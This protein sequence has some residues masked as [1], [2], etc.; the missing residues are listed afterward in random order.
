[1]SSLNSAKRKNPGKNLTSIPRPNVITSLSRTDILLGRGAFCINHIGNVRFRETCSS[2]REE[3]NSTNR[4]RN[5][6]SIAQEIVSAIGADG[7]QFLREATRLELKQAGL[8]KRTK[9]WVVAESD[10]VL[11]KVKQTLRDKDYTQKVPLANASLPSVVPDGNGPTTI[12]APDFSN[13]DPQLVAMYLF[14]TLTDVQ[15]TPLRN[16][17]SGQSKIT[18]HL[19]STTDPLHP[20]LEPNHILENVGPHPPKTMPSMERSLHLQDVNATAGLSLTRDI[21][22]GSHTE[23]LPF[24]QETISYQGTT[25][26]TT[27]MVPATFQA[28]ETHPSNFWMSEAMSANGLHQRSMESLQLGHQAVL[29]NYIQT[30]Q[31]PVASSYERLIQ[32]LG[33]Q[34][35]T[36]RLPE[37]FQGDIPHLFVQGREEPLPCR[38]G[39]NS[40]GGSYVSNAT[41]PDRNPYE[42]EQY[43]A[44]LPLAWGTERSSTSTAASTK[45]LCDQHDSSHQNDDAATLPTTTTNLYSNQALRKPGGLNTR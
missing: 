36:T 26:P 21:A 15:R 45:M 42:L 20:T 3:Y 25:Q 34:E 7:G 23:N 38:S 6:S 37:G 8:P 44:S 32:A 9:G 40:D 1:M 27:N 13:V 12:L 4:R 41:L 30:F 17:N 14:P 43:S 35:P 39:I 11:E 24:S 16:M 33:Q 31:L 22:G 18:P 19:F 5:K 28:H 2:R 29:Q 10:S